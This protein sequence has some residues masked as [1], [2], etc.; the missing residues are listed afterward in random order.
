MSLTEAIALV[1]QL[2]RR[3]DDVNHTMHGVLNNR[4][5]LAVARVLAEAARSLERSLQGRRP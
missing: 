3:N 2:L 4:T 1:N 5:S